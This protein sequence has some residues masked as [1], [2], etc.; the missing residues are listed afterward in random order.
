MRHKDGDAR[1]SRLTNLHY[2]THVENL[3]DVVFHGRRKV[4]VSMIRFMRA[5]WDD[6]WLLTRIAAHA[7]VCESHAHKIVTREYYPYVE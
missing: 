3:A 1:N 7:G 2:G 4:T 5:R 6:G